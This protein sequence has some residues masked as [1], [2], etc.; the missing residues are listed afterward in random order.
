MTDAKFRLNDLTLDAV[1]KNWLWKYVPSEDEDLWVK[2]VRSNKASKLAG[3]LVADQVILADGTSMIAL[4]DGIDPEVPQF[5]KHNRELI[6]WIDGY[7]WFR[8]ARY[9]DNEDAKHD[10][11]DN[12]LCNLLKKPIHDVFPIKFDIKNR[13]SIDSP[14]LE[15]AF[16]HDPDWGLTQR[17]VMGILVREISGKN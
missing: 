10:R 3:R 17:E 2:P 14:C 13:S 8:L 9:F 6:I 1:M 7:G 11:G 5:S 4:L 12:V 16:E 15:G